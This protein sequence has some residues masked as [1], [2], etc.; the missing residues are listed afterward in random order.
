MQ[1]HQVLK[2]NKN[3]AMSRIQWQ[4]KLREKEN[5]KKVETKEQEQDLLRI[6][7]ESETHHCELVE[8]QVRS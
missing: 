5:Q 7:E 2:L 8:Q 3:I 4:R 1:R 6:I